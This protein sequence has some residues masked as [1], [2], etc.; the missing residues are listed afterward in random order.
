[1]NND[2][3]GKAIL[4]ILITFLSVG[5]VLGQA[6][7]TPDKLPEVFYSSPKTYEI[8][9]IEVTGLGAQYDSE[10]LIQLANLRVGS[11]IRIPGDEITR[12]I[13]RLYAQGMFSDIAISIDRIEGNK[14]YLVMSLTERHKLSGVHYVGIKNAEESKIKERITLLP[15]TQ[16]T[17]NMISNLQHIVE[18]Y[19]KEKGY[20]NINIRVLQ[21][22][23]PEKPNFVILDV[24]VERKEKIK[25]S[26][27]VITGNEEVKD[28]KL[29]NA[30]KKTKEKSLANF[31]KSSKYIEANYEDDKY[32]LLDRYNE[33]GYRDA[34]IV[35]DSVVRKLQDYITAYRT[36][37]AIEDC[38]YW[39][40]L[41]HERQSEYYAAQQV[42][43]RYVDENKS[44]YT[45]KS[46][47]EG[48]RL[49]NDMN[50]AYQ[51]YNQMAQQLQLAQGKIQEAKPVFAVVNPA[52]VPV[53]PAGPRKLVILV[54][55]LFL[56]FCAESAWILF[57][58]EAW[59]KLRASLKE[60]NPK[61]T[62]I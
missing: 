49:Q 16:V 25:I 38:A 24:I 21:R 56:F 55:F 32:N 40:K 14:V 11:E 39:E 27:V 31:F 26:E 15:G 7:G 62:K 30:M 5:A 22:D 48:S 3:I 4:G 44:L 29:K 1:M 36:K 42:Y 47:V 28:K 18:R 23:D 50:L 59:K 8:G 17:D 57:G 43:A 58:E 19:F 53:K 10:T 6:T 51:V 13:K 2:M 45:E 20:Y 52:T 9:G 35:A 33:L 12:A 46:K 60:S 61:E 37:K 54:G 41:Y 34:S